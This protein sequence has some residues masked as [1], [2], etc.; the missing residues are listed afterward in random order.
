MNLKKTIPILIILLFF[1]LQ[2]RYLADLRAMFPDSF[3]AQPFCGVDAKAHLQRASDLIDGSLPG[4]QTYFFIPF[5][6]FYL[7]SL[8]SLFG[9][10]I[11]FPVYIQILGQVAA[12]AALFSIGRMLFSPLAGILASLGLATYS[13]YHFYLTCYDQA[14]M[15]APFLTLAAFFLMKYDRRRQVGLLLGAGIAF[16]MAAL[17][18][19]T[20]LIV[21][22][23]VVF[24][25]FLYRKSTLHFGRDLILLVLPFIVAASPITWHNYQ[26][27]GRL[28]LLSDNFGVNLFTGNNPDAYGLD[29]LAH[30]Q[31][32]PA[33][34][35]FLEKVKQVERG[36]TT[37]PAEVWRYVQEQPLDALALT[38]RKSWLWFGEQEEILVEPFF[39]LTVAQSRTLTVLPLAWQALAITGLLG[40]FLV[41]GRSRSR[42]VLWWL[43]YGAFSAAS[44]LFFIQ[45]RFR[46]PF[47]PFIILSAASLLAAA[48]YWKA[49]RPTYFWG[50]TLFLLILSPLV[51]G[52]ALMALLFAGF[53]LWPDLRSDRSSRYRWAALGNWGLSAGCQ[54]VEPGRSQGLRC[55]A[56][57]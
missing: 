49:R 32:Q 55:F 18:R 50:V 43:I 8:R 35:R 2:T 53:G 14:V 10:S 52:L 29:S 16:S 57:N 5:Y 21:M 3:G 17:S 11:L 45:F 30:S 6:P 22:A 7:A 41:R 48:S 34:L 56:A 38:A 33:V 23:A 19:P 27:S 39:P 24:W 28:I 51:S 54:P 44:I 12:V 20:I 46:L 4:D 31:S 26:V 9:E 1:F 47:V 15:T 25:L 40:V 13:Y 36:E 37:F 42:I